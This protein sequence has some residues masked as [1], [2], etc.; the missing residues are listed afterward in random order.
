MAKKSDKVIP[1]ITKPKTPLLKPTD[2]DEILIIN[3]EPIEED[4]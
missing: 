2:S 1:N 4:I 3:T